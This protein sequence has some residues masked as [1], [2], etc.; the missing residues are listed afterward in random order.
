MKH[1]H[2]TNWGPLPEYKLNI[3]W[4]RSNELNDLIREYSELVQIVMQ[5]TE[6]NPGGKRI[7]HWDITEQLKRMNEIK[8]YI[9]KNQPEESPYKNILTWASKSD[10]RLW[11]WKDSLVYQHK[12]KLYIYKEWIV[13]S[14]TNVEYLQKKYKILKMYLWTTIPK[15]GFILWE[16]M[17]NIDLRS[18]KWETYIASKVITIQRKI[19]GLDT[20]KMATEKKLDPT[21]LSELEKAHKKYILLKLFLWT[22]LKELELNKK[23]MDLQLDLWKLSNK[24]SFSSDDINFIKENITSPNIMWNEKNIYF[25][26]FWFWEWSENK[27]KVFEKMIEKSTYEKWLRLIE[28]Y[29]LN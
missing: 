25:I 10:N 13:A 5:Q 15:S 1:R 21:F 19:Y 24:D 16:S 26:D 27:E 8:Q 9:N 17:A 23:E 7:I 2:I 6:K 14:Y 20:S 11:S 18:F 22:I 4:I 28:I 12:N 3:N 29:R